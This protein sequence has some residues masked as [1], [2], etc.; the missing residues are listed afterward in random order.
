MKLLV[1]LYVACL[2]ITLIDG[3]KVSCGSEYRRAK[4]DLFKTYENHHKL[5]QLKSALKRTGSKCDQQCMKLQYKDVEG[6]NSLRHCIIS[7]CHATLEKTWDTFD[8]QN[9]RSN[10]EKKRR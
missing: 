8:D 1:F 7:C 2:I 6:S 10:A 3:A 5:P 9:P 4:R